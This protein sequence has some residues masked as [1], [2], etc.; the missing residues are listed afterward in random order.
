MFPNFNQLAGFEVRKSIQVP[1]LLKLGDQKTALNN[2]VES[3]DSN[4]IY[5][6]LLNLRETM[7]LGKFQVFKCC[8][9]ILHSFRN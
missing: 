4:L 2:A 8:N 9:Y 1:L 7:Q 6:V 5:D 3:G